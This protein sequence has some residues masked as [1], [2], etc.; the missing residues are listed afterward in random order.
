MKPGRSNRLASDKIYHGMVIIPHVKGH[1]QKKKFR[2][3]GNRFDNGN[4]FKI[5][6]ALRGTFITT[7][8]LKD[9]QQKKKC[10]Y[11]IPFDCDTY[12]IGRSSRHLEA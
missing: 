3:I 5:E 4:I 8:T 7:G 11:S 9:A 1:F 12:C 10:V 6:H 2:R